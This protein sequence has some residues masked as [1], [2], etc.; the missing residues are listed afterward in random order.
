MKSRFFFFS[1]CSSPKPFIY[2]LIHAFIIYSTT[3]VP[4]RAICCARS[5]GDSSDKMLVLGGL[6]TSMDWTKKQGDVGLYWITLDGLG[7]NLVWSELNWSHV[8]FSFRT[9]GLET[10]KLFCS[11]NS[12]HQ[13][14]SNPLFQDSC[15]NKMRLVCKG[16]QRWFGWV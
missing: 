1:V 14:V 12:H 15:E 10:I 16:Q 9:D 5:W 8:Y 6:Q 4:L 13:E 3:V 7:F 2:S 11:G